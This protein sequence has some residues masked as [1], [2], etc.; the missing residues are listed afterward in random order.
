MK[1]WWLQRVC[2]DIKSCHRGCFAVCH[3][4]LW[5]WLLKQNSYELRCTVQQRSWCKFFREHIR[6]GMRFYPKCQAVVWFHCREGKVRKKAGRMEN[7][8]KQSVIPPHLS[9]I[10]LSGQTGG[11]RSA[12]SNKHNTWRNCA[13]FMASHIH[14]PPPR[15]LRQISLIRYQQMVAAV[16]LFCSEDFGADTQKE[17]KASLI[18]YPAQDKH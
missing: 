13:P 12:C 7:K 5:S 8:R 10:K 14:T 18:I 16:S 9:L 1:S 17:K 6:A 11:L 2:H 3:W 4:N 15:H